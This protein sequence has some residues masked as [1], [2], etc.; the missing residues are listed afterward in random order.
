MIIKRV[1]VVYAVFLVGMFVSLQTFA[2]SSLEPD[3]S[4]DRDATFFPIDGGKIHIGN[5]NKDKKS[6]RIHLRHFGKNSEWVYYYANADIP[7]DENGKV[8]LD[9]AEACIEYTQYTSSVIGD[10]YRQAKI[11]ILFSQRGEGDGFFKVAGHVIYQK[12][13]TKINK[14]EDWN[15]SGWEYLGRLPGF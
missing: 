8:E 7:T 13:S 5:I 1:F 12:C 15:C 14:K 4:F 11:R 9:N 2:S 6:F 10:T 3:P